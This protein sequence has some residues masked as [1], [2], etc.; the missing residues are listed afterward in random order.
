MR[1]TE[2]SH[3][4]EHCS[5][6]PAPRTFMQRS[7]GKSAEH[8]T[9]RGTRGDVSRHK[10]SGP[11][12]PGR[13][14]QVGSWLSYHQLNTGRTRASRAMTPSSAVTED[15]NSSCRLKKHH[16]PMDRLTCASMHEA[17]PP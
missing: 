5:Q 13:P 16:Q 14:K 10:P 9:C 7:Q 6:V 15:R 1:R 8:F 11:Q 4:A 12:Q 3:G 17:H 2:A